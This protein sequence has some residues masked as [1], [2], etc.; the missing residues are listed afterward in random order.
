MGEA[1]RMP[2]PDRCPCCLH[3]GGA[4]FFRRKRRKPIPAQGAGLAFLHAHSWPGESIPGRD[5]G[6]GQLHREDGPAVCFRV[7]RRVQGV[8]R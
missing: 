6:G 3:P 7:F 5:S 1:L 8:W 2:V 4:G